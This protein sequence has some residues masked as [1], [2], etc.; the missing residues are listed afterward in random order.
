M[1]LFSILAYVI[2]GTVAGV[3]G[4]LLGIG[5]GVIIV[6]SLLFLFSYLNFPKEH[7]MH[8]AIGTSLACT[9]INAF[10]S[11][12][13]HNK[14]KKVDWIVI[15][16]II[17]GIAIGSLLGALIA[18][19]TSSSLLQVIFGAFL[20]CIAIQFMTPCKDVK[21]KKPTYLKMM[22]LSA[23]GSL[24]SCLANLLGIGGG[25]FMIPLLTF[26]HFSP[27]KVIGTSS[28]LSFSISFFGTLFFLYKSYFSGRESSEYIYLPALIVIGISGTCTAFY[29]VKLAQTLSLPVIRKIFAAFML[30]V[31][32]YMIIR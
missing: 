14:H 23:W 10:A 17:P 20:L 25:I 11:T 16:R 2:V 9:T 28:C 21:E 31:G 32:I 8:V 29:G 3:T 24:V 1:T 22:L 19:H 4:G 26:Y 13:F 15:Y 27:R 6:P 18:V 12:Y 5:G 30:A 7:L